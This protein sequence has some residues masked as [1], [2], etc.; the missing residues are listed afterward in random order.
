MA[1]K[2]ADS[3]KT[4]VPKKGTTLHTVLIIAI[5]IVVVVMATKIYKGL[6]AAGKALGEE[7]GDE[8]LSLQTG[9]PKARITIC[10]DIAE[11]ANRAMYRIWF[12]NII[13]AIDD[14]VLVRAC[15][16]VVSAAEAGMVSTFFKEAHSDS[17]KDTIESGNMT[18]ANRQRITYRTSFR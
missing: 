14:D 17:L 11:E 1:K 12:T 7:L 13:F 8:A 6:K 10:R 16:R 4:I 15:N 5:I 3:I 2:L 9:V 18:E